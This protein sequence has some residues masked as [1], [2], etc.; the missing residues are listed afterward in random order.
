LVITPEGTR[1]HT[2]GWKTGF[3]HIAHGAN[4]PIVLAYMDHKTKSVDFSDPILP[5]GD[6]EADFKKFAAFYAP[7]E[8]RKNEF[9]GPVKILERK[10][11]A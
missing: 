1:G 7:V 4:V 2:K 8:G 11:K 5:S 3:Y 10:K 6:V 9:F